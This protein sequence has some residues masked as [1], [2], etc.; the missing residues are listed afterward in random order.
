MID[1][2]VHLVDFKVSSIYELVRHNEDDSYTILLNSRQ[3]HNKLEQA[4]NHA[5]RHIRN[6][7]FEKRGNI[8]DL[9]HNA[10]MGE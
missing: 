9:E 2:N 1:I 8:Q 5:V 6:G 4:Y 3:A 10:H 7:D